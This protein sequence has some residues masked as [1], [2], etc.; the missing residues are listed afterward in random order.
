MTLMIVSEQQEVKE[1]RRFA[2]MRL[3]AVRCE[4]THKQTRWGRANPYLTES[5]SG[6]L[7]LA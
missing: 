6:L 2:R 7:A 5:L 1:Y 4:G 3:E